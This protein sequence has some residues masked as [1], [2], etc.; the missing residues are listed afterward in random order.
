MGLKR[1][2]LDLLGSC[3]PV[4]GGCASSCVLWEL[5]NVYVFKHLLQIDFF[6]HC[7]GINLGG[8]MLKSHYTC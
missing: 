8:P 4:K 3:V 6:S 2:E 1:Q 5:L 7:G